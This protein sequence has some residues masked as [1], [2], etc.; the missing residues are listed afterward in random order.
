[1]VSEDMLNFIQ[2]KIK[3]MKNAARSFFIPGRALR[4][5]ELADVFTSILDLSL[6]QRAV[7]LT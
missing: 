4:P 3:R 7:A 5:S 2:R 6:S 1:M